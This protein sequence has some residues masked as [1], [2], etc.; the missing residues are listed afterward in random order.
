MSIPINTILLARSMIGVGYHFRYALDLRFV[1][2][3]VCRGFACR[4][5]RAWAGYHR[6]VDAGGF[7][8]GG[9]QGSDTRS[10]ARSG[11]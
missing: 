9:R 1:V 11:A 2:C 8:G 4:G 3:R 6:R 5:V 10:G 7:R